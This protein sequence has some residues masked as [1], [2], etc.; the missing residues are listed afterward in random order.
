MAFKTFL[1]LGIVSIAALFSN[2]TK[3]NVL[4]FSIK[5]TESCSSG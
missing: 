2:S 3:D 5:L 1:K 4:L